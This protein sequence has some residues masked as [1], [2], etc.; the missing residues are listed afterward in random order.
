MERRR[1][2][3]RKRTGEDEKE[4]FFWEMKKK[5]NW[6][7][8]NNTLTLCFDLSKYGVKKELFNWYVP[9]HGS[10]YVQVCGGICCVYVACAYLSHHTA[11][12]YACSSCLGIRLLRRMLLYPVWIY[13]STL[14]GEGTFVRVGVKTEFIASWLPPRMRTARMMGHREDPPSQRGHLLQQRKRKELPMQPLQLL[15]VRRGRTEPVK[16]HI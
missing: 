7:L 2:R 13:F 16:S 8:S 1:E 11:S 12:A 6:T 4:R 10:V 15:D 9:F 3:E 14:G 5:R